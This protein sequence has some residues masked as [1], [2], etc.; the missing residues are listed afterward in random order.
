[1]SQR[2]TRNNRNKS[3]DYQ[4]KFL[5]EISGLDNRAGRRAAKRVFTDCPECGVRLKE[6]N[7]EHHM[8]VLHAF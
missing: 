7:V 1:M 6:Q 8:E 5:S 2:P 3:R 4:R